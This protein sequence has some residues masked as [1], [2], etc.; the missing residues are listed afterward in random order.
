M[1]SSVEDIKNKIRKNTRKN[2]SYIHPV[3]SYD[4]IAKI[5]SAYSNSQGGDII[6]GVKDEGERLRVE[7]YPFQ[8]KMKKLYDLLEGNAKVESSYFRIDSK[9]L[10]YISVEKSSDLIK[11]NNTPYIF[12]KKGNFKEMKIV[13]VF[14]SYAHKDRD[15]VNIIEESFQNYKN[16]NL[17]RD[18]YATKYKDSLDNFMKTIR[19]H[20]YVISIVSS[21]YIKSLNC[22]YEIENLMKDCEY[23]D[24]LFFIVVGKEDIGYYNKANIYLDFEAGIYD[25]N[26]RLQYIAYWR[27]KQEELH[28]NIKEATL[29]PESMQNIS[30]DMRKLDAIIPSMD[31]FI[32]L[33]S[34]K[35]GRTF[36]EMYKSNFQEILSTLDI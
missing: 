4:Y 28:K 5:V 2:T 9:N 14:I 10:Y 17:T 22:M 30:K 1:F 27:S 31:D 33:L 3:E 25:L 11:V 32:S 26:K 29:P 13:K 7:K 12:D 21:A 15:L 6:F 36:D 35:V 18:I 34:D 16:I 24:K 20:D 8:F 23:E 19:E